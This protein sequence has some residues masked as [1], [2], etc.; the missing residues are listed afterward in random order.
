MQA[1]LAGFPDVV[2][3]LATHGADISATDVDGR[4][5]LMLASDD[6]ETVDMLLDLGSDYK[7]RDKE[8]MTPLMLA[9]ERY[10]PTKVDTLISAGAGKESVGAAKAYIAAITTKDRSAIDRKEDGYRI[11]TE[12]YLK[13]G[14]KKK[15]V[16]TSKQALDVL[17]E[18]AHL[19]F[20]LGWTY[21]RVGDRES[22]L[23]QYRLLM[24]RA[25]KA[26]DEKTRENYRDWA[27]GLLEE[28]DERSP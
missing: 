1:A 21:L 24:D 8:G 27:E 28:L 20:R 7:Q 23:A 16:E 17:G 5:A 6:K 9:V 14:Y 2:M 19:H 12:I 3:M 18:E 10:E 25:D 15:A 11:L 4:N 22:A 26:H 13:M